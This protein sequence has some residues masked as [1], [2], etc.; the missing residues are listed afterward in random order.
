VTTICTFTNQAEAGFC[1]SFLQ[2]HGV[3]AVL[4][5]EGSFAWNFAGHSIPIRLQVPEEQVEAARA[6]LA[7]A[8]SGTTHGNADPDAT[9]TT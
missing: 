1:A 2:A 4:L 8:T 5:D 7:S 3:D 9:P 6:C